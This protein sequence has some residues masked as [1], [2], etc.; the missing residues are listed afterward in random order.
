VKHK[1]IRLDSAQ[2]DLFHTLNSLFGEEFDDH[3]TYTKNRPD[4][5]YVSSLLSSDSFIAL[6]AIVDSEIVGGL[7]AYELKKFEQKR[8]EVY[9]YDLAVSEA[10]RRKGVATHLIEHLKPIAK[11]MKAWVI[12]VQADYVDDPAVALYTKLG[13]REEVLHFDIPVLQA[14]SHI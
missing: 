5:E 9:I 14:S 3:N 11:S 4:N 2:I 6:V 13:V 1:I 8:S 10:Y 12:F 7:V